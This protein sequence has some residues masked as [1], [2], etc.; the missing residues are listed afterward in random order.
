M[1]CSFLWYVQD[2]GNVS[3]GHG[4]KYVCEDANVQMET[5]DHMEP[6]YGI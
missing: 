5:F 3:N 6:T 4:S 1:M 2:L